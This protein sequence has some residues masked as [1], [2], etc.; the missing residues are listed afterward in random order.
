MKLLSVDLIIFE[1]YKYLLWLRIDKLH[2]STISQL[3]EYI[4]YRDRKRF[5]EVVG[6]KI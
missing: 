1:L 2:S 4:C 6:M 5:I 3:H